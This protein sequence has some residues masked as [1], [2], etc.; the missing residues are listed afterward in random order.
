MKSALELFGRLEAFQDCLKWVRADS[1]AY[2]SLKNRVD[3]LKYV[4]ERFRNA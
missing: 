4:L 3:E 1:S 2:R